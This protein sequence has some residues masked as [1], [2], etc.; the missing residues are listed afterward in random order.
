MSNIRKIMN[1]LE[2]MKSQW[3]SPDELRR[4]Q[5]KKLRAIIKHCYEKIP[6]YHEKFKNNN[7]RPDEIKTIKDLTK[8]PY[9][10]KQ[11]IQENFPTRIVA[12]NVNLNN[13][14]IS[15]T[16]G[17][18]GTPLSMV[19]D[20]SAEDFEKSTALR[21]NISCGQKIRDKWA[22]I[23]NPS[24]VKSKKWFQ[25]LQFFSPEYISIAKDTSSQIVDLN[26]FQPNIIDGF[27]SSIYLIAKE[28]DKQ[29]HEHIHPNMI[30]TTSELI[31]K[32][33]KNFIKSVFD[34]DVFD[35]FGC[36]ELGRTA[37]ECPSHQGYHID[38][39]SVVMEFIKDDEQIESNESGE[40]VYTGLYNYAMPLIR[41]KIGD[42]GTP[43]SEKCNCGRGLPLMSVIEGRKDDFLISNDGD[44]ISPRI[45]GEKFRNFEGVS[46]YKLIQQNKEEV[47]ILLVKN[48]NFVPTLEKMIKKEICQTLGE[49]TICIIEYPEEIPREKSG[50]IRKI[51][52]K[53]NF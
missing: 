33:E 6:L 26:K 9:I 47:K 53:V 22:V 5:E 41:Y 21:P 15:K 27:T 24:H 10:T 38:V 46:N 50:K 51:I 42:I 25:Y 35:Q 1:L 2:L 16:G 45:I 52:S 29:A 37:W 7:I 12:L 23:T 14:W 49:K 20:K 48:K 3:Y 17:S 28:L 32:A 30:F 34:A 40:I 36:V 43:S 19:Y 4:I 13:C 39:E 11:E 44:K 18:T 8:I 31:T